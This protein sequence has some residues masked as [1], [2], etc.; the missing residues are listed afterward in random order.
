VGTAVADR[1]DSSAGVSGRRAGA[2]RTALVLGLIAA[3]VFVYTFFR[4][5]DLG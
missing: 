4:Y 2:R 1:Q 5:G 3:A